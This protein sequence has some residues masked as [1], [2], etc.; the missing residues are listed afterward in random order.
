M[1]KNHI[2]LAFRSFWNRKLTTAINIFGLSFGIACASIAF[3]FIQQEYSFDQFH[4]ESEK[5]IGGCAQARHGNDGF[6]FIIYGSSGKG[7][8]HGTAP[9]AQGSTGS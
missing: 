5:M 4:E 3:V 8:D 9:H 2:K 1:L 7:N 6:F